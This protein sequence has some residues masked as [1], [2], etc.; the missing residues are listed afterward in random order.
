MNQSSEPRLGLQAPQPHAP[1]SVM[2]IDGPAQS[3][4]CA[5][6]T[7][8]AGPKPKPIL[9]ILDDEEGPR[10]SLQIVFKDDYQVLLAD[11]GPT[12]VAL[13]KKHPIDVAV[14]DI[15]MKGMSG[16]EVL[17][18]LKH[19]DPTTEVVML[20]GYETVDTTRQ[21][22]RLGAS[23]YLSKP[24]GIATIREAVR[25]AL[26]HR[27]ASLQVRNS[28]LRLRDL[29]DQ[30]QDQRMREELARTRGEIY[31][32]IIHDINSPLTVISGFIDVVCQRIAE[33]SRLEG[34]QFEFVKERLSR[35]SRQVTS[36]IQISNRYLSF[37]RSTTDQVPSVSVNQI[38]SDAREVLTGHV[39]AQ[40]HALAVSLLTDDC[41]A[42][43]NGTDLI[44][45]LYNLAVN[46]FQSAEV[47]HRVEIRAEPCG[48]PLDLSGLK[49][50]PQDLFVS[51]KM[52]A[53]TPPM[54][55][56]IVA[57][58]GP[59]MSPELVGK[60][61]DSY[62]TTKP[63]GQGTGLGLAIVKRLVEHAGGAIRLHTEV[64]RGT[65]FTV[66][67]PVHSPAPR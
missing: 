58:D 43:I 10:Q 40:N 37:L 17:H 3:F 57:D 26:Q 19:I 35:V 50:G 62:F 24:F 54:L 15:R 67:L 5:T 12:A 6:A 14:L 60:V 41:T 13:A 55:A 65:V 61:F 11:N 21:A 49:D 33:V 32:S 59:G 48:E 22:L 30:I 56:I 9:L 1:A 8:P 29:Q 45:V 52:F 7:S 42:R 47:P 51:G 34:E 4:V 66:Y 31:A 63:P 46:A 39:D 28:V 36:C 2:S 64:G 16:I 23:D 38:L 18:A 27:T 25:A 20:T 53:N 44:Q